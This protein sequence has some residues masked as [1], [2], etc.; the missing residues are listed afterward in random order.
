VVDELPTPGTLTI[1]NG[2]LNRTR[3]LGIS[4]QC[5]QS[6]LSLWTGLSPLAL[7]L[8]SIALAVVLWGVGY[9]LSR[10][11]NHPGPSSRITFT[12]L[13]IKRYSESLAVPPTFRVKSHVAPNSQALPVREAALSARCAA[14]IASDLHAQ[15]FETST[16]LI[17]ARSPPSNR[18]LFS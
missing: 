10:Y 9:R 16:Y 2:P 8:V 18:F 7:G 5:R 13:G 15:G 4:A 11:H 1:S 12:K 6:S 3:D 17:P 14:K